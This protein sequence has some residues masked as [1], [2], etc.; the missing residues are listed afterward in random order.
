MLHISIQAI[1]LYFTSGT[2]LVIAFYSFFIFGMLIDD[3]VK[4]T[5]LF[6]K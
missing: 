6:S 5:C 4:C 2:M 1:N 3:C